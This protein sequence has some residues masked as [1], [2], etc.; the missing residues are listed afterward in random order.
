MGGAKAETPDATA[1]GA[2]LRRSII[3]RFAAKLDRYLPSDGS[4]THWTIS[5]LEAALSND[6]N[7]L[8]R[9]V[10]ESCILVHPERV[11]E[12]P[13]CPKCGKEV[14]TIER[15]RSTHKHTVVGPVRYRRTY[16]TCHACGV[17]FSPSGHC[18]RLRDGLL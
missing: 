13:I 1:G 11:P 14:R 9:N 12:R 15:E 17:A 7:E 10:V 3:E 8:A 5:R 16:A 18:V 2:A 6:M 4:P